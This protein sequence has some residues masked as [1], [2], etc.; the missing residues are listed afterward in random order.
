MKYLKIVHLCK[1]SK[2]ALIEL[3]FFNFINNKGFTLKTFFKFSLILIILVLMNNPVFSQ[4]QDSTS[5]YTIENL[6]PLINTSGVDYAPCI[7][8]DG[9]VLYYVSDKIGSLKD[10]KGVISHDIWYAV[11]D[12]I[13]GDL[14]IKTENLDTINIPY[15]QG[16]NSNLNEGACSFSNLYNSIFFSACDRYDGLGSC[17]IYYV[18]FENN[19][20]SKAINL[21]PAINSKYWDSQP[22]IT[23]NGLR[24]Y[25]LSNRPGPNSNGGNGG[26]NFDIWY[27]DL[28]TTRNVWGKAKNLI[29]INTSGKEYSP[30]IAPNGKTLYFASDSYS[31]NYGGLD[32][33][34]VVYDSL[35]NKWSEPENLGL[36]INTDEDEMF[37][38]I[39]SSGDVIYFSSRRDDIPGRVGNLDIYRAFRKRQTNTK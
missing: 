35:T 36:P 30:F 34:K 17:D 29:E 25:F 4:E 15:N 3:L 6:G 2:F 22:S 38:S 37:L 31:P 19:K 23:L 21:G 14:F 18:T 28:D 5:N 39:P 27:S 8:P 16:V 12:S 10:Q 20:W 9:K 1:C 11:K 33:Y 7:T 26:N 13:N 32:F 24:I